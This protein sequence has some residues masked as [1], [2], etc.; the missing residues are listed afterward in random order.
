MTDLKRGDKK[1]LKS[2]REALNGDKKA[3]NYNEDALKADAVA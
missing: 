3:F 1:V 2:G